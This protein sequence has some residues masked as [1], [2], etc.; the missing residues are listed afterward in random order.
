MKLGMKLALIFTGVIA[1][2][3]VAYPEPNMFLVSFLSIAAI[4]S[5]YADRE[6]KEE[7][8]TE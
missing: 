2:L 4:I 7:S 6:Q 8:E 3:F 1:L 5:L